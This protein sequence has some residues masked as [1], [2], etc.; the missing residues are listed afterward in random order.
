MNIYKKTDTNIWT[1]RTSDDQLYLHEKVTCIDLENDELPE[2]QNTDFAIL[3]YVCDEGVRRNSGRIGAALAPDTIRKMMGSLSNHF[4][5][6][7]Q[8]IDTGNIIC[9]KN[10]LEYTQSYTSGKI[11]QLLDKKYFTILFGGGHDLAYAHYNGIKKHKPN[12]TIGI[13]NLD[14]HFDLRKAKNEGNSGTP[15]YQIA[16]ENDRFKYICLGIQEESN[17]REL[18][19]IANELEVQYIKNTDFTFE[20]KDHVITVINNFISSVDHV[21]LTIDL[22]GF[23]SAYAPGVS[24][25][26]PFGFSLDIAMTVIEQ[27]CKSGKLISTDIVELNPKYDIDNC[28]SRLAARLAYYIMKFISS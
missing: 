20:N 21:Y 4:D 9:N 22:D 1:G 7:V 11:S 26:S 16:K 27:I 23:S 28:T 10:D 18:F 19:E 24:A 2:N 15:F 12:T 8:I 6:E 5:N 13:I 17:N 3:G 14:A 25:P